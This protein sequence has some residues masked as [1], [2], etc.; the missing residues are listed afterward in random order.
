MIGGRLA[1]ASL[2]IAGTIVVACSKR[3]NLPAGTPAPGD[4]GQTPGRETL[5]PLVLPDVSALADSVQR[6]VRDRDARLTQTLGKPAAASDERAAA[7]GALGQVLLAAKFHDA[8]ASCFLH[9]EALAPEDMRWPYYVGHAY[10][11]KG[12]RARAAAAFERTLKLRPADLTTLVWLGETYL[13][14]SRLDQAQSAF[15][16][17]ISLQPQSAVALFGAGRTALARQAYAEAAQDMERA[18][19]LDRRASAIHY[20]LAMAYRALGERDKA[21]AHLRQRGS[22]FP[23][24]PDPLM[25]AD[26]EVLDSTVAFEDRGMRALKSADF[27]AA[28]TAFRQ[29]L[30]LAPDDASLRYWL[31]AALYAAGD[32]AGAE[33][34]FLAVLA[35]SPDFAKAHFSLG[36]IEDARG[37]R[38]EAVEHFRAAVRSDPGMPEAHLR[39]ADDLRAAGQ[40][41][42][43]VPE[44]EAAVKLDPG[45]AE[46][47]IDGAEA[48]IQLGR[49][50]QA[51][52][53]LTRARR[54]HPARPELDRLQ[55]SVMKER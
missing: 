22:A 16:R 12:D 45:T 37:R 33:R 52:D 24:L 18:L 14:D 26:D 23:D 30:D 29:G 17:A 34:E 44:Y 43:S 39:L 10:L 9:A 27:A 2:L 21:E 41:E 50:Q 40:V 55:G 15:E 48:L 36:A 47:W 1:F 7:Y 13:D 8:A 46:A 5:A 42:A 49:K 32:T 53:W 28:A 4:A 38:R 19:A 3:A 20:P 25:Q 54:V 51:I 35:R 6:Q 11:R 31:G